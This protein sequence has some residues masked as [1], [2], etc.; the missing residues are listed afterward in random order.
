MRKLVAAFA[1]LFFAAPLLLWAGGV[2]AR[3]F[4]NRPMAPRPALS[5]GWDAFD[6]ATRFFVDRLPL[7]EQAV[8]ANTW[9][10]VNVFDTT[11]DY[12]GG[13]E[14][15]LPFGKPEQPA[16]PTPTPAPG[17]APPPTGVL[18]GRDG[19]LFLEA[20]L[21][22]AC[23][24]SIAWDEAM[25]RYRRLIE[26]IRDSGRKVA[27]VIPPD[28]STVYSRYL[29]KD[30]FAEQDCY[31]AGKREGWRRVE[32]AGLPELLPLRKTM[33][34]GRADPPQESYWPE[35]THWNTKG[36][37]QAARAVL[38]HLD[39][40]PIRESEIVKG[41]VEHTGDLA[42]LIGANA[43]RTGPDWKIQRPA[44]APVY[45]GRTAFLI[46]SFGPTLAVGL[47]P[48]M[49]E[50]VPADWLTTPADQLIQAI[51]AA[52]TVILEKV[53]RDVTYLVSDAGIVT[54]AFMDALEAALAAAG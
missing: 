52:D 50:L 7:R 19:W 25:R 49:Q 45:P 37:V 21:Q 5:D 4:E 44:G 28:K 26:L 11:P 10:S 12:S 29:P 36:G 27:F 42:A 16:K 39:G 30:G 32:D 9:V 31:A 51:V 1:L 23:K 38:E 3:P 17:A 35:D 53:E 40:P 14:N 54:P 48:Y 47:T 34:A 2:R 24:P 20:D 8:R 43:T 46:D 18:K 6:G 13:E 22:N 15:A 41:R 33:L